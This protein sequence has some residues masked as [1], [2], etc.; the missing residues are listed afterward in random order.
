[1]R[2]LAIALCLLSSAGSSLTAQ[3]AYRPPRPV[4]ID[5]LDAP[6]APAVSVS[7]ERQWLLLLEQRSMPTIAELARPMLRLAGSR[8]D[9]RNNG[10]HQPSLITGL[11]FERVADGTQRRIATPASGIGFPSWS[12]DGRRIAFTISGDSAI[13]LWVADVATAQARQLAIPPLNAANGQ[14]CQW[15]PASAR[16]LCLFVPDGRRPP[17]PAPD[18][19]PGAPFQQTSA[20]P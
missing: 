18:V 6:P 4:V 20:R 14:P 16:L 11:V 13:A 19:P 7:P 2:C 17:P 1:M 8:I 15:M 12:P 3:S 5:I 10:P 9:A